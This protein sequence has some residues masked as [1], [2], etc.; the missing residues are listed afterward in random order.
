MKK[1]PL[2]QQLLKAPYDGYVYAYPHKTAYRTIEPAVSL[3][4]AW[5][6]EDKSALF[7]YVHVP[8]C[9]MRCGFCNLFT[10]ANPKSDLQNPFL[11]ALERQIR[12][13]Q[14]ALAESGSDFQFSRMALGGGTPTFLSL[15]DLQRLFALVKTHLG[16]DPQFIPSAIEVSPGT[17]DKE[18]LA[19]LRE[20]GVERVSMGVQSFHADIAN[21]MGRPVKADEVDHAL[22][23]LRIADFPRLNL[24][25]IYGGAGQTEEKWAQ[26]LEITVSHGP[27]EIYLYPLYVRP[28]TGLDKMSRSWDDHRLALYQQGRDYLLSQGYEQ[29]SMRMFRK[30]K[31]VNHEGPVY[32]CQEDGMI[33]I[34]PG[35]RSYT[36]DLHYSSEYA[37]GRPGLKQIIGDYNSAQEEDFAQIR[38]GVSLGLTEQKRR[39][40]LKSLLNREGMSELAYQNWFGAE[41][42]VD[43]PELFQLAEAGLA[44]LQNGSWQLSEDGMML[45]DAIGPWLYSPE[46]MAKMGAYAWS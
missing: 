19:F 36:N 39:Y 31:L 7:L 29:V 23:L 4:E 13:T 43:F 22:E 41:V 9:E 21:A 15:P 27:E 2:V 20:A 26:S 18:K 24:D 8:F 42:A 37:V 44:E 34:G 25:L 11:D 1:H 5:R 45:S 35:A 6:K 46:V 28:L 33:G 40:L 38:H 14:K 16:L 10:V 30:V 12:T 3:A 17:V 32:C